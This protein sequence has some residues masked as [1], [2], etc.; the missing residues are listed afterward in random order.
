MITNIIFSKDRGMQLHCLLSSLEQYAPLFFDT[1]VIYTY[2]N[3]KY[4]EGYDIIK[5][6][7]K[8]V[9]FIKE[10]NLKAN[11]LSNMNTFLTC[12]MVDDQIMF[13]QPPILNPI[14]ENQCFSL[15]LGS[16]IGKP[17]IEYPLSVDGHIFRTED[18]KP[19]IQSIGF[20]NPNKLESKLQ[21][22]KNGWDIMY[23][24][25]CIVSVPH[26]RVS[27]KSHC[28]FTGEYPQDVL[29]EYLLDGYEINYNKMDF[30]NLNNVHASIP[31]AFRLRETN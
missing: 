2:S 16:N 8:D 13:Q 11:V 7:H 29:N 26:N 1:K 12:F 9:L 20:N 14:M 23:L 31:Y 28:K 22:Y 25:Q 30:S 24:Y 18:I 15:R 27:S 6:F 17:H 4:R 21:R 10:E 3:D 19:L 5:E